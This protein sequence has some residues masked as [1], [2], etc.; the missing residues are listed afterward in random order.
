MLLLSDLRDEIV[1]AYVSGDRA[2]NTVELIGESFLATEPTIFGAPN[3]DYIKREL[4]WYASGSLNVNDIP[5]G[6]P[7]IWRTIADSDGFINSN[8]GFLV[9]DSGNH[10]Q[11][12]HVVSALLSDLGTRRAVAIYTRPTMHQDWNVNGKQD[13]VCT[14]AVQYLVRDGKL[15][16]V[17]QMRS[18]DVVFG[19]RNDYAWQKFTQEL[20]IADLEEHGIMVEPG[21]I[22]WHAASLHVY[23]RHF[24]LLDHFLQTGD[25]TPDLSLGSAA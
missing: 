21:D 25:P 7:K 9:F 15:H 18:N 4:S 16:L 3:D 12:D 19:Y 10:S 17:V 11:L 5:G 22:I 2:G 14:N 23:D 20:V 6:A 24:W 13:F 1:R 8:Y